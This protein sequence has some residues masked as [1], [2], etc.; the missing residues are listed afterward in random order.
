MEAGGSAGGRHRPWWV[1]TKP[2][3]G[4]AIFG[5]GCVPIVGRCAVDAG[6]K[7][8]P[9]SGGREASPVELFLGVTAVDCL[10]SSLPRL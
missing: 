3:A 7:A 9:E 10:W 1:S 2:G 5:K 4:V 8:G 6:G